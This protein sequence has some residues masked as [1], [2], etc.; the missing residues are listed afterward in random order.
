MFTN[1]AVPR[2]N[3][4]G[5]V[6][7]HDP[8]AADPN[9]PANRAAVAGLSLVGDS[10]PFRSGV[11]PEPGRTAGDA[12]VGA[13]ALPT[14]RLCEPTDD[15]DLLAVHDD[16]GILGEPGIRNPTGEPVGRVRRVGLV[17]LLPAARAAEPPPMSMV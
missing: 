11:F 8:F 9:T 15:G 4:N 1:L 12:G 3:G 2:H 14:L 5:Q 17:R 7:E 13:L 16:R 6:G 10:H